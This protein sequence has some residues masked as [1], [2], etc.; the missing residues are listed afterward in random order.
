MFYTS[1]YPRV[2]SNV[3]IFLPILRE[4]IT[5]FKPSLSSIGQVFLYRFRIKPRE[6][7]A[8]KTFKKQIIQMGD[9]S[10]IMVG[11][12][13]TSSNPRAIVIY[14]HT[15]CG[16]YT[17]LA[18]IADHLHDNNI[19]YAT[20]TR[21]GNDESL[22]FCKY[23]LVGRIEELQ[24]VLSFL[25]LQFPNIPIHAIG[26]S[27]GSALLIRYLGK[28]NSDKT[29]KSAILISPGYNFVL[30]L[31]KMNRISQSYLVNKLK[32]T[33]RHMPCRERMKSIKTLH[34]WLEFQSEL[35]GYQSK[36]AYIKE[37]DPVHYLDK[38]NVPSL[39]VS[40]LDDNVF[41]SSITKSFLHLPYINENVAIVTTTRGGHVMFED[42]GYDTAWFIR[43]IKE[44]ISSKIKK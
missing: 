8:S 24:I 14:L 2:Y 12:R 44:W 5:W 10:E 40:A 37:C 29:I 31:D 17:Q 23:N 3:P 30:S 28:Y 19:V 25:Q 21:S 4:K 43:L 1:E 34:D 27:A 18:H 13:A 26:A 15:V 42:H 33:T 35:L 11:Y 16:D 32:Y 22:A 39:F 41:H 38:I 9:G 7:D 6:I 36:E 20:Y